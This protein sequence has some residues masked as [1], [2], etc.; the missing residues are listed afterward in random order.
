M[1]SVEKKIKCSHTFVWRPCV[2]EPNRSGWKTGV[3]VRE[4]GFIKVNGKLETNVAC[5]YALGDVEWRPA[6]YA[7]WPTTITPLSHRNLIE[8]ANYIST[9]QRPIPYCMFTDPRSLAG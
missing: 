9:Q 6:I 8:G 1:Q 4:S 5:I 7:Y 2:F 3:A